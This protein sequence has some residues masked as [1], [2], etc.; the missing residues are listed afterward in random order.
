MA[1]LEN[2]EGIYFDIRPIAY[3]F[4]DEDDSVN[5]LQIRLR[6]NNGTYLW[7]TTDPALENYEISALIKWLRQLIANDPVVKMSFYATEPCI[8]FAAKRKN[9][10]VELTVLLGYE[11]LP[12]QMK[13][14][15]KDYSQQISMTFVDD[16]QNLLQFADE[17]EKEIE[18]FPIRKER[19]DDQ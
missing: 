12:P 16:G 7:E 5:W 4:P 3:Q 14:G 15:K 18:P 13:V 2:N 10:K 8:E 6:A 19:Y 11:F 1:R 17:F 9:G